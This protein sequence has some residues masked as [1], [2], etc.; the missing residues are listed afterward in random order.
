MKIHKYVDRCPCGHRRPNLVYQRPAGLELARVEIDW[1]DYQ[2]KFYTIGLEDRA[3]V[4]AQDKK[5]LFHL[6]NVDVDDMIQWRLEVKSKMNETLTRNFK[7][8]L[9]GEFKDFFEDFCATPP[10]PPQLSENEK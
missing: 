1:K 2:N 7:I 8:L 5:C 3:V 9:N 6:K 4:L 10:P